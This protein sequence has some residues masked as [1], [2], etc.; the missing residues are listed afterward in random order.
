MA[1]ERYMNFDFTFQGQRT[2]AQVNFEENDVTLIQTPPG[3]GKADVIILPLDQLIK[4]ADEANEQ[5]ARNG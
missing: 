5:K 4:M 3:G 1:K 2:T